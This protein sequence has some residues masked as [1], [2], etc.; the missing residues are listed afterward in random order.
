MTLRHP[1]PNPSPDNL[2][3]GFLMGQTITRFDA[4]AWPTCLIHFS[5]G[6][7]LS[8]SSLWRVV[9]D[10]RIAVTS[11][12]HQQQF[13]LP[14]P[15]HAPGRAMEALKTLAIGAVSVGPDT[16][17]LHLHFGNGVRFECLAESSGYENW[18]V[19]KANGELLVAL[20][21]GEL[22]FFARTD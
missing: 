13:G 14:A 20:G 8:T 11:A 16:G 15:V 22:A 12:D 9:A 19:R 18:D 6:D 3:L 7:V 10:G 21:G 1:H 5:R 17:D 2:S 4:T